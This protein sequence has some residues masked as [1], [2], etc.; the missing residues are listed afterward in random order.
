M[1]VAVVTPRFPPDAGGVEE[2]AAWVAR[3]L[4]AAGHEVV[5]IATGETARPRRP[6]PGS[7]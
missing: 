2:Y 3:T 1:K 7:R 6:T 5:V 4:V